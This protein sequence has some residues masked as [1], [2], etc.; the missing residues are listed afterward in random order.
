MK[1]LTL[2]ASATLASAAW[3]ADFVDLDTN[4]DG[5][6][7]VEEAAI[8]EDLDLVAADTDGDGVISVEEYDAAT[9]VPTEEMLLPEATD[10]ATDE[11]PVVE[12]ADEAPVLEDLPEEPAAEEAV[13]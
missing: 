9:A 1:I 4:A 5:V 12:D 8:A 13:Q 6:L 2:L 10:E 3:A 7:S 11:A